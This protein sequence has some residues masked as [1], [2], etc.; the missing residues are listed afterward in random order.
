MGQVAADR[1]RTRAVQ[2]A[3]VLESASAAGDDEVI[4]R[5]RRDGFVTEDDLFR[6]G[7]ELRGARNFWPL[8][9]LGLLAPEYT[10]FDV[11]NVPRGAQRLGRTMVDDVTDG[12]LDEV[13]LQFDVPVVF[14]LGRF[15]YN[16][17][18][19]LAAE[20]LER[21]EA[22]RKSMVWFEE[23]AHFPFLEE[24]QRFRAEL[25]RLHA[26]LEDG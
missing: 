21:I 20:Y 15:D 12:A 6:Y 23:S 25:L 9:R 13:A 4:A 17:P 19:K 14:F 18:S 11:P 2:R 16:T 5:V 24:P 26:D 10:L 8:L 7:G 22:P 1:E 3:F